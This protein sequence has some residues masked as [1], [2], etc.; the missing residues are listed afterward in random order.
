MVHQNHESSEQRVQWTPRTE[1]AK[2]LSNGEKLLPIAEIAET[3]GLSATPDTTQRWC[4]VGVRGARL[5][6]LKFG[7]QWRTTTSLFLKWLEES[8]AP[9]APSGD[10]RC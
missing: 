8:G 5:S 1:V 10:E 7:T 4:T 9:S 3:F 2:C 6:A